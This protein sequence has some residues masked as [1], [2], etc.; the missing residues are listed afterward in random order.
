MGGSGRSRLPLPL[1]ANPWIWQWLVSKAHFCL[2][3]V[4][5]GACS[6]LKAYRAQA[7]TE[8]SDTIRLWPCCQGT[9]VT[10]RC[11]WRIWVC[12]MWM[13]L[14]GIMLSEISQTEK[15]KYH[16]DLTDVWN[17]KKKKKSWATENTLVVA[18]EAEGG[19]GWNGWTGSKCINFQ[20][21]K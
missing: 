9:W 11:V 21:T 20:F 2:S 15:R 13:D 14:V 8:N 17:L 7:E 12:W 6:E 1:R 19:S 18:R 16:W 3:V 10:Q 5:R 4:L